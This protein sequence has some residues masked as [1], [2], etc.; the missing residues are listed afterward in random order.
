MTSRNPPS[1]DATTGT[2]AVLSDEIISIS[3][4][5]SSDSDSASESLSSWGVID[6]DFPS[7]VAAANNSYAGF[8]P[9]VE[10]DAEDDVVAEVEDDDAVVVVVEVEDDDTDVEKD[11][12]EIVDEP[13]LS[14]SENNSST[15]TT[16][17]K[18]DNNTNSNNNNHINN[19]TTIQPLSKQ[20]DREINQPNSAL[21]TTENDSNNGSEN[22]QHND[23]N[24]DTN[25]DTK[26]KY[27][28]KNKDNEDSIHDDGEEDTSIPAP[29]DVPVPFVVGLQTRTIIEELK[30][31][32]V[33]D[34]SNNDQ[35]QQ[36]QDRQQQSAVEYAKAEKIADTTADWGAYLR[37]YEDLQ[38]VIDKNDYQKAR[39]HYLEYGFN[40]GRDCG[41][42]AAEKIADT[43]A[44]WGAY[45]RRYEDLQK[46]I[47]KD[48]YQKAR[49]HYLEYGFT[50]NRD[51]GPGT[52]EK[53]AA[54]TADWGAYL[55]RYEDLQKVI[56]KNDYQKARQHYLEY[57]FKEGRDC[58]P[59]IAEKLAASANW[60]EYLQRYE[61]LHKAFGDDYEKAQQ[62][63]LEYGYRE[64]RNPFP[65][66]GFVAVPSVDSLAA[67]ADWAAYLRRNTDLQKACGNDH[68]KAKAHFLEYGYQEKRYAGPDLLLPPPKA[69]SIPAWSDFYTR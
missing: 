57:G 1:N 34:N 10:A 29:P 30:N 26:D 17:H 18:N 47:A 28:T 39:Q 19:N 21:P 63:Y 65:S 62:H 5:N 68:Q 44:D 51:C 52:A 35:Q 11:A 23:T 36:L 6:S 55:R 53:L 61:D 33:G 8:P 42:G 15:D 12:T 40:E 31:I 24:D 60:G 69:R 46:V 67:T 64:G 37:R 38:K 45:L 22:N 16:K 2:G 49:Q 20:E 41:P 56:D 50:E 48:D 66:S 13:T 58:G 59:G 4:S 14:Y 27:D 3:N 43:T 9:T 32:F 54:T 25:D 7:V